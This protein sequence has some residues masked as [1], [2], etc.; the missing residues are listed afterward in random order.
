MK[1]DLLARADW[2][3]RESRLIRDQAHQDR[4]DTRIAVARVRA[5]VRLARAETDRSVSQCET[6]SQFVLSS[7]DE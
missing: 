6:A 5:T 3:I 1:D 7:T 4:M 2:A